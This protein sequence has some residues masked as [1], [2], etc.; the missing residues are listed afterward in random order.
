MALGRLAGAIIFGLVIVALLLCGT[1]MAGAD[2]LGLWMDKD[3]TTIRVQAC[4]QA[5]CGTIVGLRQAV[6]PATGRPRTDRNNSDRALRERPLVGVPVFLTMQPAGANRWSGQLYDPDRGNIYDGH[7]IE[8]APDTL[9][10]E[11]CLLVLCGG[12]NLTRVGK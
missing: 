10:V 12:E 5:L 9:R 3:G 7:L 1:D 6:D 2:P 8:V 4:G 11:G